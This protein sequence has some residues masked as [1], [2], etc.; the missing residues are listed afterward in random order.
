MDNRRT[1]TIQSFETATGTIDY[2]LTNDFMF[3]V[4]LEESD[5]R[6]IRKLL[7]SLL[8]IHSEEIIDVRVENPI[9]YGTSITDKKVI[10]DLKLLLNNDTL[11]QEIKVSAEK[12]GVKVKGI[13]A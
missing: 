9:D 1:H 12:L 7:C 10:L 13:N 4:V 11:V 2:P 3:H 6:V 5:D 8:H